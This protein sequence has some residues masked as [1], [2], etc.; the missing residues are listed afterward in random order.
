MSL[1]RPHPFRFSLLSQDSFRQ[2]LTR[3]DESF[4]RY[5]EDIAQICTKRFVSTFTKIGFYERYRRDILI[6]D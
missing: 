6:L 2:R 4:H 5:S 3:R 1:L